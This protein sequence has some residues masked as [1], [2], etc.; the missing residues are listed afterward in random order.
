[1][2]QKNSNKFEIHIFVWNR[3]GQQAYSPRRGA[4]NDKQNDAEMQEMHFRD[5]GW[6]FIE[7][8]LTARRFHI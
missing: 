5:D 4:S 8:A 2:I 7:M 6:S 1:M 3:R